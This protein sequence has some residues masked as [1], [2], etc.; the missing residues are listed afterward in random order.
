MKNNK[1]IFG[2]T[3]AA[4]LI[5]LAACGGSPAEKMHKNMEKSVEV[6]DEASGVQKN[7][8][9]LEKEEKK[10]YD[11]IVGLGDKEMTKIKK[12]SDEAK[13][14]I[15]KRNDLIKKEKEIMDNSK[16][17]FDKVKD[18]IDKL[19]SD[20]EKEKAKKMYDAMEKR[21]KIYDKLNK[22]YKSSLS[23]EKKMYNMFAAK[24]SEYD[25]V[26][27]QIEK[28]NNSYSELVDTNKEFNEQTKK[29]NELKKSF[30]KSTDLEIKY[31]K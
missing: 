13:S 6:E 1:L 20:K 7:I 15:E 29:Y 23:D 28:V 14:N 21:Y 5:L 19:D 18:Q 12:I 27:K 8:I 10:H 17:A 11:E 3:L 16:E 31:K 24:D 22:T 26:M 4:L 2:L 30:Y 9:D 25:G